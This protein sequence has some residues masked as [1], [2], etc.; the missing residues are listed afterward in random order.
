MWPLP[1][2]SLLGHNTGF[3]HFAHFLGFAH[4]CEARAGQLA[5]FQTFPSKLLQH[6]W[7]AGTEV[8][9]STSG[10]NWNNWK[11]I[12][13]L[14]HCWSIS[15]LF[16]LT[17]STLIR[18]RPQ[19]SFTPAPSSNAHRVHV[20]SFGVDVAET[21]FLNCAILLFLLF[22]LY[23]FSSRSVEECMKRVLVMLHLAHLTL[24]QYC[25]HP[26]AH[27]AGN[28]HV[29]SFGVLQCREVRFSNCAIFLFLLLALLPSS[30][31][32]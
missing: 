2:F 27:D 25:H 17:S 21:R 31:S 5:Q 14:T 4:P 18:G 20:I 13:I 7:L 3:Y 28:I 24:L 32:P 10:R 30:W 26:I 9:S 15:L 16:S 6:T 19:N 22:M 29:M 8:S 1:S 12:L 11:A 23:P